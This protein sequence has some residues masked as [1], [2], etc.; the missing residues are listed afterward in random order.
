MPILQGHE[1]HII[2]KACELLLQGDVLA[3]PTE[4]V[5]G[6]AAIATSETAIRKVYQLKQR[7]LNHPLIVHIGNSNLLHEYAEAIPDYVYTLLD[8][9]WP[10]PLTVVLPKSAQVSSSITAHQDSVALRMPS[11]PLT[12]KLLQTLQ[13]GVVAPS[14]NQFGAISPTCAQHV[15][16]EFADDV[17]IMD[18]GES[19]IGIESTIIN[20]MQ[21]DSLSILRPG[22]ITQTALMHVLAKHPTIKIVG[23]STNIK[24][25]GRLKKHY[26]PKK[27]ITLFSTRDELIHYQ[28]KWPQNIFV[29]HYSAQF[30]K[31]SLSKQ[32][33][34]D[35]TS[36]GHAL[37][38]ALREAD[39]SNAVA[40]AVEKPPMEEAWNAISDR[41]TKSSAQAAVMT[42][43]DDK[44]E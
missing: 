1:D 8:F 43:I 10:G 18:G 22:H 31:N 24:A 20:A 32:M 9:F 7:P 42:G 3:I 25:P 44:N 27:P 29:I 40:I 38:S 39:C 41:L 12:L 14:A 13:C 16:D 4:T 2:K 21:P 23:E 33:P 28:E 35:A 36:Y 15:Q 5:Y 34:A 11:H 30:K 17:M 37:Y 26:A 6:L 19:H